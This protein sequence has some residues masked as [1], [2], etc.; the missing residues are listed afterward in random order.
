MLQ[1]RHYLNSLTLLAPECELLY[2][3]RAL[4]FGVINSHITSQLLLVISQRYY[5]LNTFGTPAITF[6]YVTVG[7]CETVYYHFITGVISNHSFWHCELTEPPP[8]HMDMPRKKWYCKYLV[9]LVS[10]VEEQRSNGLLSLALS[11]GSI[12]QDIT[13]V[14]YLYIP[15]FSCIF[16]MIFKMN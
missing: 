15:S 14:N 13:L 10:L 4:T 9:K 7:C 11:D 6:Q 3:T 1:I 2:H 5:T 8:D 16:L 12:N